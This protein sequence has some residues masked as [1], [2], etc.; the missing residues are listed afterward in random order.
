MMQDK[1]E[2]LIYAPNF[3]RENERLRIVNSA[4][5]KIANKMRLKVQV[6]PRKEL[7]SIYVYFRN[8]NSEEIP[9]YS[10]WGKK[11]SEEDVYSAIRNIIFVL[12]FHPK[13][14]FLRKARLS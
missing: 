8:G 7:T 5:A 10:D 13:Y 6:A 3:H 4:V 9:L 14:L 2:I 11:G 1:A 12:S